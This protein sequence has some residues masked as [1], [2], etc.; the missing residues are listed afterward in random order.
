ML[1][2]IEL[3]A[4]EIWKDIDNYEGIYQVSNLGRIKSLTR[5]V[6]NGKGYFIKQEQILN[7]Y[8][9]KKGYLHIDLKDKTHK[10]HRI[11]ANAFVENIKNKPQ[12]NHKDGNK[13]NNNVDNLEWVDNSEN[14][15]HAYKYK[16]NIHSEFS[17]KSKKSVNQIDL[18]TGKI[19]NTYSSISQAAET[20]KLNKSNIGTVC[21]G[22]RN[23]CGGYFWAYSNNT[24]LREEV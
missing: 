10:V 23:H 3:F 22:Q 18:Y 16:L 13:T 7:P 24:E 14:Q 17:G 12:V 11:V 6:W 1:R 19:L 4:E 8:K 9:T 20:L 21:R 2:V 5:Y 15:L